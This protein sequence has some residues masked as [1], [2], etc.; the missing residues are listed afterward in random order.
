LTHP[1]DRTTGW[2]VG[3]LAETGGS[4]RPDR[5]G[6]T[7]GQVE[8]GRGACWRQ[9]R[10]G[11]GQ[12]Q[13]NEDGAD[14]WGASVDRELCLLLE[15]LPRVAESL[16][17][18]DAAFAIEFFEQGFWRILSFTGEDGELLVSCTSGDAWTPSPD[19]ARISRRDLSAMLASLVESFCRAA[20]AAC[21]GLVAHSWFAEWRESLSLLTKPPSGN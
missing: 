10:P 20:G 9:R 19:Q 3:H 17:G 11:R 13:V 15:Q 12:A 16:A 5:L 2:V 14:D 21:P 6:Q 18:D 4:L 7:E 8:L 1:F